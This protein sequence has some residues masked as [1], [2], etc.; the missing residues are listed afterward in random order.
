MTLP[1]RTLP[2]VPV[3][4]ALRGLGAAFFMLYST[5][6]A[7]YRIQTAGLNALELV[8][9]GTVLELSVFLFEIPTGVVAD[10]FSRKL[11]IVIG[12]CLFGVGFI[13]EGTN[14][15]FAT[16]LAAQVLW[17]LG[18]TFTSGAVGAWIV[19]ELGG[20]DFG[21]VLVRGAQVAQFG[22]VVGIAAS[23]ALAS[24]DLALPM[25]V[26]GELFL[27]L[28]LFLAIAMPEE[29]FHPRS[30]EERRSWQTM[31]E[32][33]GEGVRVIRRKPALT[34]ILAVALFSGLSSEPLDRLW[35]MHFL[36]S[37]TLP[38]LGNLEPVVWFGIINIVALGLG[39]AAMEWL[40][41]SVDVDDSRV[42]VRILLGLNAALIVSVAVF[43][44]TR[45]FPL[46][47]SAYWASRVVRSTSGPLLATWTNQQLEPRVRATVLSMRT[48][49]DSLG[50]VIGG[51]ILG[52]VAT[53]TSI[54]V[55]MMGVAL[56]VVP[57]QALYSRARRHQRGPSTPARAR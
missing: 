29:G 10:V 31:W 50:Q 36:T 45:S 11:S 12:F 25:L 1:F 49:T 52:A 9:V 38:A 24:W 3:Y 56:L 16:I 2:P 44:L 7:I 20:R 21:P 30:R 39:I 4:L 48:Q 51:P 13:V 46:A 23:V 19:D 8:L 55:A 17:G 35:E 42:A 40:R 26:G 28:S 34:I 15:F 37:F 53:A 27:G 33:A 6:S 32:T 43:A 57:I 18:S 5:I 22:A 14:P 41:R 47:L 54:R